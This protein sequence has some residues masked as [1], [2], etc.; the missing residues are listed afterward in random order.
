MSVLS[1]DDVRAALQRLTGWRHEGKAI[2]RQYEFPTFADAV[3]FVNRVADAADAAD[4]HPDIDIRY[5]KVR[6]VLSTHSEGG[7]T[8]KDVE[9]A[10]RADDL[11]TP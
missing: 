6:L 7:I 8:G 1:D 10:G 5:N 3:A 2:S 4:H 11:A 9:L